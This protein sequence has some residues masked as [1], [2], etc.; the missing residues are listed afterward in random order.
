[1]SLFGALTV[2]GHQGPMRRGNRTANSRIFIRHLGR[3]PTS[4]SRKRITYRASLGKTRSKTIGYLNRGLLKKLKYLLR[5]C[6]ELRDEKYL[7]SRICSA[8]APV[9]QV[10][11]GPVV[12]SCW[13][14]FSMLGSIRRA[15]YSANL[16]AA[17]ERLGAL[18]ARHC[19]RCW[20]C[21]QGRY[22]FIVSSCD[23]VW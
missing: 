23:C 18:R 11:V 3:H 22:R 10:L 7:S 6:G 16:R 12:Q 13:C 5:T 9:T 14:D 20:R 2:G 17:G 8:L 1:M 15:R 4:C 21:R 19:V